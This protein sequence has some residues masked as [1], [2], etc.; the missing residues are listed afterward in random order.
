MNEERYVFEIF[1]L[2]RLQF[3]CFVRPRWPS[4]RKIA[5]LVGVIMFPLIMFCLAYLANFGLYPRLLY[6]RSNRGKMNSIVCLLRMIIIIKLLGE[7]EKS[8]HRAFMYNSL[9]TNTTIITNFLP[10]NI[11]DAPTIKPNSFK[12]V[13]YYGFPSSSAALQPDQI[14]AYL[15]THINAAFGGVV[16]NSLH[17]D[18]A[19]IK[20]LK[21]LVKLKRLNHK[22]KILVC[23]GGASND[24]GFS[25]MV[26]NHTNRKR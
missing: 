24:G 5:L 19:S 9:P 11:Y 15:C 25:E 18:D 22:L 2:K 26:M 16:N 14:D 12:L 1:F 23:I 13:C 21:E 8:I 3:I 20:A 4:D 17:I 7:F 6:P 10:E